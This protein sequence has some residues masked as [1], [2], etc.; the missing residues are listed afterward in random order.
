MRR[1]R[2]LRCLWHGIDWRH[3]WCPIVVNIAHADGSVSYDARRPCC[4][5]KYRRPGE[6][7]SPRRDWTSNEER[8]AHDRGVFG[9]CRGYP[10]GQR[11]NGK[12]MSTQFI[13]P[14]EQAVGS[15]RMKIPVGRAA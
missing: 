10:M 13:E 6:Q 4:P 15:R 5:R 2:G 11:A 9:V 12:P 14:P 8:F 1:R 3:C 7:Y